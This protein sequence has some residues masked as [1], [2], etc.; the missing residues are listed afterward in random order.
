[1][2]YKSFQRI[3]GDPDEP[4]NVMRTAL[5]VIPKKPF[6]DWLKSIDPKDDHAEQMEGDVYLLPDYETPG[7]MEGW[8]KKN[9]NK[10]FIHQLN[11]W[12]VDETVWP[13]A[14]TF[15]MFK[16][17]FQYSTHTMVWDTQDNFI[18]KV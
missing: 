7:Q 18:E 15:K 16:E 9:F 1:M 11:T 14:R 4:D 13:P 5:V 10:I 3:A 2:D 12:Y 8:L 17:W 6:A